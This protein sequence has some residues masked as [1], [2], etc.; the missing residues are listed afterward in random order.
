VFVENVT[1]IDDKIILRAH[2]T[3]A[4]TLVA[5]VRRVPAAGEPR[6]IAPYRSRRR[7]TPRSS[8]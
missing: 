2:V 3:R 1:D 4:E 8:V 7:R 6:L 5:A